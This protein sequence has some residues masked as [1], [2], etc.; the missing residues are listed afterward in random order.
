MIGVVA[1]AAGA[2]TFAYFS[3]IETSTGNTFTSGIIDMEIG[4]DPVMPIT[5]EDM[6]PC[7]WKYVTYTLTKVE[8]SNSGPI[9]L[10]IAVVEPGYNVVTSEPEGEAGALINDIENK[11]TVDLEVDGK[12]IIPP[13][14]DI[15]LSE[16]HCKWIPLGW[17]GDD[18][19]E[20]TLSFHLQADTG[21]EYQGDGV[22]FN[23]EFQMTD[24]NMPPPAENVIILENKDP[25]T[26]EPI[27]DDTWGIAMYETGSLDL[28][29]YAQGL[30]PNT[31]YQISINSP[32]KADWYP[33]T[34]D[35]RTSMANALAAGEYSTT[36][37][38]APPSGYNLF[39]RGYYDLSVGGNL[40]STP[41]GGWQ[42]D[43]I[44]TFTTSKS[45]V[46]PRTIT[47]DAFGCFFEAVSFDL[48]SGAYK[49]IKVTVKEDFSPYKPVLMEKDTPLTFTIP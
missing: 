13:E 6:K 37:Q 17:L 18:D 32:E 14:A 7:D 22:K 45:G 42:D 44:G 46:T 15:K 40:Q 39:E 4:S 34:E 49:C 25:T 11:I 8:D 5:L 21:N 30:T 31:D 23:V 19:V 36:L 48:P 3:D 12:V 26:W 33:V 47:T 29:V 1:M 35:E 38:T 2:G 16:L 43:T 27:K 41:P 20:V 9:Y 28:I 24:H 10:H